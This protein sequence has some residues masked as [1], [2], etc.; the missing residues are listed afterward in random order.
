MLNEVMAREHI[1][2][3]RNYR[4]DGLVVELKCVPPKESVTETGPEDVLKKTI[5]TTDSWRGPDEL[6]KGCKEVHFCGVVRVNWLDSQEDSV[7]PNSQFWGHTQFADQQYLRFKVVS[8]NERVRQLSNFLLL[9][10]R[11]FKLL[12]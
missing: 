8:L 12:E 7:H 10:H 9:N 3:S 1:P 5:A 6:E 2:L 4:I 11:A